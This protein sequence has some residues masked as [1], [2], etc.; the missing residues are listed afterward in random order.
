MSLQKVG[1]LK[2]CD[3]LTLVSFSQLDIYVILVFYAEYI[4]TLLL[5]F[6]DNLT[7]VLHNDGDSS[8]TETEN[9]K[10]R[11]FRAQT[12]PTCQTVS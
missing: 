11:K 8:H 12:V 7:A 1:C 4:A 9:K 2:P 5:T 10:I 6:R 3:D